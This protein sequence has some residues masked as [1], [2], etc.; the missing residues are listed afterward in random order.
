MVFFLPLS[1]Y[2]PEEIS[3]FIATS[4][5]L[6]FIGIIQVT[7]LLL[8]D[9]FQRRLKQYRLVYRSLGYWVE[10][11]RNTKVGT[12]QSWDESQSPQI[13]EKQL[14]I[15]YQGQ[16]YLKVIGG[17]SYYMINKERAPL[18]DILL[19]VALKGTSSIKAVG[20]IL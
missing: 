2:E 11:G 12:V 19:L 1:C 17:T 7:V 20:R 9:F 16:I 15:E 6:F 13:L 4:C 3:N 8:S 14:I 18:I 10:G 5:V